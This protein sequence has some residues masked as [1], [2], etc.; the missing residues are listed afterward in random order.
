[1]PFVAEHDGSTVTP[2]ESTSE[3]GLACPECDGP[4]TLVQ[5]HERNGSFVASHFRHPGS[6]SG[7]G[8]GNGNGNGGNGRCGGESPTHEKMKSIAADRLRYDY[9]V[10]ID[11]LHIDS[12]FIGEK[13]PD[14]LLV[15]KA[16]R[17]SLGR[18][19]AVE[20]QYRNKDK[21][22]DATEQA[23]LEAGYT[24]L[25]LEEDAFDLDSYDVDFDRGEWVPVWPNAVPEIDPDYA[26]HQRYTIS[27]YR[28]IQTGPRQAHTVESEVAVPATFYLDRWVRERDE[29]P[30][31][32][33]WGFHASEAEY[34]YGSRKAPPF[35]SGLTGAIGLDDYRRR[36]WSREQSDP[37][38][39][40]TV[41]PT[42]SLEWWRDELRAAYYR[43][44]NIAHREDLRERLARGDIRCPPHPV[45]IA[46]D[47][48]LSGSM[49]RPDGHDWVELDGYYWRECRR[50]GLADVTVSDFGQPVDTPN[51]DRATLP[52]RKI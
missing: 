27:G 13:L 49:C 21:D 33:Q 38:A 4:L 7:N 28:H 40:G 45:S 14:V 26:G 19:I 11:D 51:A 25:W 17:R 10:E 31:A 22:R 30:P 15:F 5:R 18:G 29:L 43:G 48:I 50:C 24:T 20:C 9:G 41:P 16:P 44:V 34:A 42:V 1:M 36:V 3:M 35:T 52:A 37:G 39:V 46:L 32:K 12:K 8:N 47:A 6:G 23:Y 2:A